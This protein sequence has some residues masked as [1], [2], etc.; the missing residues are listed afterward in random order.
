MDAFFNLFVT[1]Q[2]KTADSFEEIKKK[3]KSNKKKEQ[4]KK[5]K[6]EQ[7]EKLKKEQEEQLKKEQEEQKEQLKKEQEEEQ[8]KK[9]QEEKLKKEQE[10]K[11]KKEQEE[12]LKKEQEEKLKKEQE[13]KL[14]KEQEEQLKKE[15]EEKLKK[16]QEKKHKGIKTH[17]REL[18]VEKCKSILKINLK[19]VKN[20][21]SNNKINTKD[22]STFIPVEKAISSLKL[23]DFIKKI[24]TDKSDKNKDNH[25]NVDSEDYRKSGKDDKDDHSSIDSEDYRKSYNDDKDDKDDKDNKKNHSSVDSEYSEDYRKSDKYNKDDKDYHSSVDSEYSEYSEDSEDCRKSDTD[26]HTIR[27]NDDDIENYEIKNKDTILKRLRLNSVNISKHNCIIINDDI[28]KNKSILLKILNN[29]NNFNNKNNKLDEIYNNTIRFIVNSDDKKEYKKILLEYPDSYFE[30]F[31]FN[32]IYHENDKSL[33]QLYVIDYDIIKND[34]QLY[35]KIKNNNTNAQYIFIG[36]NT[37]IDTMFLNDFH[38]GNSIIFHTVDNENN[39]SNK[40]FYKKIIEKCVEYPIIPDYKSYKKI[41]NDND[42]K[43]LIIMNK[44]LKFN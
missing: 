31:S 26:K 22:E 25:S 8:L 30:S 11:L 42:V 28:K 35:T 9:E 21:S 40:H 37:E 20:K 19:E 14:K 32:K 44:Q 27:I 15:Q 1:K 41:L 4:E 6:K 29:L 17:K 12:K 10:E 13:E 39:E 34:D 18:P 36:F 16:E 3:E 2:Y 7:E 5:L 24:L 23:K 33:K 43:L 38:Y